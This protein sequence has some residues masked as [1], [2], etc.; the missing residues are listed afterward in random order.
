MTAAQ[1]AF[2]YVLDNVKISSCVFGT[3]NLSNLHEIIDSSDL[4]LKE[5]N[6]LKILKTFKSLKENISL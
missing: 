6:K 5:S 2:A 3:T 1:A 4:V